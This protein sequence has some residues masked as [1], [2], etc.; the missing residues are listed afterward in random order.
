MLWL[1][2]SPYVPAFLLEA[3]TIY[4]WSVVFRELGY[5]GVYA[6]TGPSSHC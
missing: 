6:E 5:A 1:Q 2:E 4:V 3:M